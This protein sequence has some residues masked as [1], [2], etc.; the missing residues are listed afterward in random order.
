MTVQGSKKICRLFCQMVDR[1]DGMI[2]FVMIFQ[3]KNVYKLNLFFTR[4][5]SVSH[6]SQVVQILLFS[7]TTQFEV[8]FSVKDFLFVER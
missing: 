5:T 4:T 8:S 7:E 1:F 3:L 6:S 2:C